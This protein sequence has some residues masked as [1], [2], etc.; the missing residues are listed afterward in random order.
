MGMGKYLRWPN[1]LWG[2]E[3]HGESSVPRLSYS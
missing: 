2:F 3:W 1:Y